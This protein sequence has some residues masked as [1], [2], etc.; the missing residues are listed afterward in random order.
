MRC[1]PSSMIEEGW[2]VRSAGPDPNS[3]SKPLV[4]ESRRDSG[5]GTSRIGSRRPLESRGKID[6]QVVQAVRA[7]ELRAMPTVVDHL[8]P[9]GRRRVKDPLGAGL[10]HQQ[11]VAPQDEQHGTRDAVEPEGVAQL[12]QYPPADSEHP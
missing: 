11:V 10:D 1:G 2:R 7:L 5:S 12:R 8:E 9:S 3:R 6:Q 4:A